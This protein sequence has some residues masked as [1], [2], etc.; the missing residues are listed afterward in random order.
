[1]D[2]FKLASLQAIKKP[3]KIP[4]EKRNIIDK[5]VP[6]AKLCEVLFLNNKW[7]ALIK[8]ERYKLV[9]TDEDYQNAKFVFSSPANKNW[10]YYTIR[11]FD[12][13]VS[14]KDYDAKKVWWLIYPNQKVYVIIE[15]NIAKLD[16]NRLNERNGRKFTKLKPTYYADR[17]N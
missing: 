7:Y 6:R 12:G 16:I 10:D 5:N 15:N 3:V 8:N 14:L 1:M 17:R 11:P 13:V 2:V 9:I 4:K